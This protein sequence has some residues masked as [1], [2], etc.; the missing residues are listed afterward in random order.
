MFTLINLSGYD[1]MVL[2]KQGELIAV[3]TE[4]QCE[5]YAE[6][7]NLGTYQIN[8]LDEKFEE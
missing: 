1:L 8:Y 2:V 4:A 5:E 7:M 6:Q 3:G